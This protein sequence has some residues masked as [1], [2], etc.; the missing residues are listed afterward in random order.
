MRLVL[1]KMRELILSSNVYEK[2]IALLLATG[3]RPIGLFVKNK[4]SVVKDKPSWIRVDGIAKKRE[5]QKD[6]TIRPVL[7]FSPE[8]VIQGVDQN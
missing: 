2:A 5:G 7:M 6:W 1:D 3:A 8:T 4:Y